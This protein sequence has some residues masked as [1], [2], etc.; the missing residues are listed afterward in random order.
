MATVAVN[1]DNFASTIDGSDVVLMDFWASWCGPCM[2]FGP[3]YEDASN[4]HEDVT[5]AKLDTEAE[6]DVAAALEISSIPTIMAFREGQ[7]V[8]RQAGLLNGRQ[9]D[10]LIGQIKAIPA[11]ELAKAKASEGAE[12]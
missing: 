11:E 3:I 7:L 6:R 2:R 4:R 10:D 9:L 1:K 8:F 5:F 12:A